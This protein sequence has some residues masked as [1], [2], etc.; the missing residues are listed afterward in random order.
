M[1]K[2]NLDCLINDYNEYLKVDHK[3]D[4]I[5][6]L[7]K[8]KKIRIEHNG[9][10]VN[11]TKNPMKKISQFD[12]YVDMGRSILGTISDNIIRHN[13]DYSKTF[14]QYKKRLEKQINDCNL[15]KYEIKKHK[16][17]QTY[18]FLCLVTDK[19]NNIFI[20]DV[21]KFLPQNINYHEKLIEQLSSNIVFYKNNVNNYDK[22]YNNV[23]IQK[24][25]SMFNIYLSNEMS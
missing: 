7:I 13:V 15:I 9:N 22:K 2:R 6:G 23:I 16:L 11:I 1:L 10:I 18:W 3:L 4:E 14:I 12:S 25:I 21:M 5:Y 24:I 20:S 17:T 19:N 8:N